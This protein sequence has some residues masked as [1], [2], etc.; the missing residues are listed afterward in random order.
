[1]ENHNM[2]DKDS[3]VDKGTES[4]TTDEG[5]DKAA[6]QRSSQQDADVSAQIQQLN[7]QVQQLTRRL[8]S[9]KDR[10]VKKTNERL[11]VIE[12][13]LR[14][15]L[16]QAQQSGKSVTDILTEMDATEEQEARRAFLEVAQQLRSGKFPGQ[17]QGS[18]QEQGVDVSKVLEELA[19]SEADREDVRV[20]TYQATKF[21]SEADAYRAAVALQKSL[22]AKPSEADL[23]SD[24]AKQRASAGKQEQLVAEYNEGSK[25]LFG[26]ALI[27]YKAEMRKKGLRIS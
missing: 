19:L 24:I 8:Q 22:I 1:M 2:S 15:V 6:S 9:D 3:V 20:K 16:Q 17:V 23:P 18:G 12:G 13:D 27:N 4:E 14:T 5:S 26:Q 11:D 25:K 10:A 7:Q 21:A